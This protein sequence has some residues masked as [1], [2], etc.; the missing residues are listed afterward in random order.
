[1]FTRRDR[2]GDA[3]K[4]RVCLYRPYFVRPLPTSNISALAGAISATIACLHVMSNFVRQC[5]SVPASTP[6][7][8]RLVVKAR[9]Q[10]Q[11]D[12]GR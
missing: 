10:S 12:H 7:R 8:Q 3:V 11:T 4:T 9:V 2:S 5:D 1:M 6:T